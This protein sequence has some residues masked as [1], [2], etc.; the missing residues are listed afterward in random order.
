MQPS[1]RDRWVKAI[2]GGPDNPHHL[3]PT[4]QSSAH[5]N[6]NQPCVPTGLYAR[7]DVAG[8]LPGAVN[9]RSDCTST[10]LVS[11]SRPIA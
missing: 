3:R 5:A 7:D 10:P 2:V 8:R 6:V 1:M 9:Q 4:G 11:W